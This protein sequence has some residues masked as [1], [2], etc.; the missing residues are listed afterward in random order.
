M[1]ES[2]DEKLRQLF[3]VNYTYYLDWLAKNVQTLLLTHKT[4]Q[5]IC[6]GGKFVIS[7]LSDMMY[8]TNDYS[9]LLHFLA[10][11]TFPREKLE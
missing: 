10:C 4:F 3:T 11:R 8:V 9:K 7:N 1:L 6:L 5:V 2:F